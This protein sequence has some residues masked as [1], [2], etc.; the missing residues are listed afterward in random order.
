MA[1]AWNGGSRV[2][3]YVIRYSS[4]NG[5]T[6]RRFRDSISAA[7]TA[8]VTGLTNEVAYVFKV[9]AVNAAGAGGPSGVSAS[10]TPRTVPG[11][12]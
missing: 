11:L 7:T 10:V 5:V 3:D 6:W 9:S 12:P 2:T 1:P 4:D 8:T